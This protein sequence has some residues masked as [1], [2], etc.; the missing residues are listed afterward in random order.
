MET[1]LVPKIITAF[2]LGIKTLTLVF[3][4]GMCVYLRGIA[5]FYELKFAHVEEKADNSDT[6]SK[7]A[8]KI[9]KKAIKVSYHTQR[10]II[11]LSE[12][13]DDRE[14]GSRGKT[15]RNIIPKNG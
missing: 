13:F 12:K 8:L 15:Y 14:T 4:I 3:I 10:K 9:S 2:D 1:L 6:R 7:N 11:K 5:K